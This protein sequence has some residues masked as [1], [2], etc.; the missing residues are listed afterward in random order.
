LKDS[1]AKTVE[2]RLEQRKIL[3][4]LL[5]TA[6]FSNTGLMEWKKSQPKLT[7][8]VNDD[9]QPTYEEVPPRLVLHDEVLSDIQIFI[10]NQVQQVVSRAFED[11][12]YGRVLHHL[13][14]TDL[15]QLLLSSIAK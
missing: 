10:K 15:G 6:F 12:L 4:Q 9:G 11:K 2:G 7:G 1:L 13:N 14:T 3:A 8:E 5:G